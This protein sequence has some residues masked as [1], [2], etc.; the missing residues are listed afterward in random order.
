MCTVP[1]AIACFWAMDKA[2]TELANSVGFW[3]IYETNEWMIYKQHAEYW[4]VEF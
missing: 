2:C 3:S 1:E 4:Y